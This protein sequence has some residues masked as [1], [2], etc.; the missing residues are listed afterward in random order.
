MSGRRLAGVVHVTG[1]DGQAYVLTPDGELPSW[2][3][4]RITNPAAWV[5][6][7][8]ASPAAPADP[9]SSS[10]SST[11][12]AAAQDGPQGPPP[13]R[14]GRGSGQQAWATYAAA[15]GVTV[16]DGTSRE[17]II[18]VLDAAGVPTS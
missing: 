16:P 9:S 13:P 7:D 14:T 4:E 18:A 10:P 17:D 8:T 2:A 5:G 11:S 15:C 12:T 6:A 1:P 3:E